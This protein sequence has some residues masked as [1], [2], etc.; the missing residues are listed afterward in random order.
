MTLGEFYKNE[1]RPVYVDGC[2]TYCCAVEYDCIMNKNFENLLPVELSKIK[3]IDIDKCVK[4]CKSNY[5]QSRLRKCVFFIK[6]V[7]RCAFDNGYIDRNV[8]AGLK[9]PRKQAKSPKYFSDCEALKFL[10]GGSDNLSKMFR[11][12]ALTGLRKEELLA[13]T[14]DNVHLCEQSYLYIC[15]TIVVIKGGSEL[16]NDTKSHKNRYVPLC[17]P[18]VEILISIPHTSKFVF[19]NGA[20]SYISPYTYND[21]YRRLYT[22][23]NEQYRKTHLDKSLPYLSG[24]KLRHT[25]ASYLLQTGVDIETVRDLLGHSSVTTTMLYSHTTEPIKFNAVSTLNNLF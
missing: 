6:K 16:R 18:A 24:H 20:G 5:S 10:V 9:L 2:V 1:F 8:T 23:K 14:W 25:F 21:M 11:F 7:F 15:Q 12:L 3:V 4:T 19:D 22:Q 17:V 13:L